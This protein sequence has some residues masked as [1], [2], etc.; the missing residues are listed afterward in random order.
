MR[1]LFGT[2]GM[3]GVAGEKPLDKD[4]LYRLGRALTTELRVSGLGEK[5]QICLG[6][7]TRESCHWIS[8]S[9]A[10]GIADGGGEP[11]HAGVLP[12]PALALLTREGD[13]AAG[14]MISASH[15]PYLDNGV[16]IFDGNGKKLSDAAELAIEQRIESEPGSDHPGPEGVHDEKRLHE[17]YL[18]FLDRCMN[19]C[20]L[21]G[22]KVVLD[23]AHGAA[24]EVGPEAF[25]NAGAEVVVVGNQPNG[26]NINDGFG[27]LH[28][29]V[30]ARIVRDQGA[31]FGFSF[32]GDADRCIATS[33]S[34]RMLDGDF[35]LYYVGRALHGE[36]RLPKSTVVATVMSNLGLQKALETKGISMLRTPVG[37]RYV[38]EAM[39]QYGYSLGGEQSGH[40]ILMDYAPTGD[41]VL[42]ALTLARV[43]REGAGDLDATLEE[44]PHFPQRLINIK[45]H[46]K[47]AIE[48][49]PRLLEAVRTAESEMGEDGRVVVRY[50]GTEPKARVMIEGVDQDQVE[51]LAEEVAQRFRDEIGVC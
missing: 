31:D 9:L 24:F 44:I 29:E 25:R 26:R 13:C 48:E 47:P 45:V 7:D 36:G 15:N 43:W 46:S 27:S 10:H 19:G 14:M 39:D 41:G 33:A 28:P 20:R 38:L 11:V 30:A 5:P 3:R 37:D 12:T 50:S 49:N 40:V 32:D 18:G 16:K 42:S 17:S 21:D 2:D 4:T 1:K 6:L 51:R 34:G 35:F 23:C 22:L 8:A